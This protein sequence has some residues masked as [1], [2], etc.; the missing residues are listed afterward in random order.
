MT[1]ITTGAPPGGGLCFAGYASVFD[2]PDR[3]RDVVAPGAFA[4]WLAESRSVLPLLW[5]HEAREPVG[6]VLHLAE[7]AR[8][9]R[10]VAVLAEG[11]GRGRDAAALLRA[12]ALAGLSI[13][14]RVRR[15]EADPRR[16]LRRLTELELIEISLVT[17]P[18]QPAARVLAL[19]DSLLAR[20]PLTAPIWR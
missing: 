17:F 6:R 4:R 1:E 12:G 2:L 20:E 14:Y 3:G 19:D 13:G 10:V 9:L 18:M 7:D 15:A 11:C 5:Q 16:R 8:G